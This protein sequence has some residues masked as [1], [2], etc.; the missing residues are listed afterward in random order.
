MESNYSDQNAI[1][2][3]ANVRPTFLTVICILTF[4]GSGATLFGAIFSYFS[5][6]SSA[7]LMQNMANAEGA[8]ALG[9]MSSLQDSMQKAIENAVPN[10]IIGVISSM[11]C[12]YGAIK[13]WNLKKIGFFI[14]LFGELLQPISAFILGGGGLIASFGA[15]FGLIIAIVWIILYALNFKHLN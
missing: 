12:L 3:P 14:Y 10:L 1:Q 9:M 5:V 8:D 15:A 2:T 13:M 7:D 4:I 11:L 6:Q